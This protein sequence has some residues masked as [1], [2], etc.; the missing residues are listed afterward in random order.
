MGL[1]DSFANKV[2][3][4]LTWK[5]GQEISSGVSKGVSNIFN[6][7]KG[8]NNKCP[9][10][11]TKITDTTLRFCPKCGQKL[12]VSCSKCTLDFP[13]GTEFCTQCGAKVK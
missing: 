12:I 6:K 3:D 7:E 13:M 9:K 2:K 10:C 1:L 11:K 5:A 4:D 8:S